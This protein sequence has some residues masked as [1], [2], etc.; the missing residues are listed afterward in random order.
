MK[1][2]GGMT[3]RFFLKLPVGMLSLKR[4]TSSVFASFIKSLPVRTVEN[5]TFK[6]NAATG[7]IEWDR[8]KDQEYRLTVGGLVKKAVSFSYNDLKSLPKFEQVSDFHCV[9]GWSVPDIRWEGF[10]FREIMS[11]VE[12]MPQ[13]THIVFHSLGKTGSTP[14]G[15]DHFI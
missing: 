14:K 3:R 4:M 10:R 15:Q 2:F 5:R 6:F 1:Y 9:E 13:A 7:L 11:R 8:N 12:P